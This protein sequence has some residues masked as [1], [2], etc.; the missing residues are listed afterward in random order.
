[1]EG[2]PHRRAPASTRRHE[3][4]AQREQQQNAGR[5]GQ[6]RRVGTLGT[7]HQRCVEDRPPG[8]LGMLGG[9]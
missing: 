9:R 1:M 5:A 6:G 7:Q 4:H 2:S 8:R 3:Q